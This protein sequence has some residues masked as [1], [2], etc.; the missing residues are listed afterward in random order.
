MAPSLDPHVVPV[1]AGLRRSLGVFSALASVAAAGWVVVAVA[2][3]G[4]TALDPAPYLP[5]SELPFPRETVELALP[6]LLALPL[7]LVA[8][9]QARSGR[10]LRG[11]RWLAWGLF[12]VALAKVMPRGVLSPGWFLQPLLVVLTAVGFGVVPG[13]AMA[14][15]AAIALATCAQFQE[16]AFSSFSSRAYAL[17]VVAILLAGGLLGAMLHRALLSLFELEVAQ[18]DRIEETLRA[19]RQRERLLRHAMR[20]A[21]IGEMTAMAVHQLR[22]KFQVVNGHV[23]LGMRADPEEKDRRLEQIRLALESSSNALE[24]LLAMAHPG[25]GSAQTVSLT[26]ECRSF[27]ERVRSIL[28]AAIALETDLPESP[29]FVHL[30]PEEL[31][32]ALSNLVINAKQAMR[33]GTIR[34]GV[35]AD[36]SE[37]VLTVAD[38]GP[39]IDPEILPRIFTP[40]VTSKPK[41]QGTGLGL[42]GVDRFMRASGGHVSVVSEPG[43]GVTFTLRFPSVASATHE[44]GSVG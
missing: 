36:G 28:P 21:T 30:V 10:L 1:V 37:A 12:V 16:V 19:L 32:H 2:L 25:E 34:I 23:A 14:L 31:D 39:G 11:G 20:V 44:L 17:P 9:G 38:D 22:N 33:Q 41:G 4:F 27:V 24:Q 3:H 5:W 13:L 43:R 6:C 42:V 7:F 40:F 35:Q 29:L 26:E 15:V 18:R 8:N